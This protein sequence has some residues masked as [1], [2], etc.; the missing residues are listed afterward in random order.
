M[1]DDLI[2]RSHL[3]S[4]LV[5]LL[6]AFPREGWPDRQGFSGLAA[7]WLER[8][9]AFPQLLATLKAEAEATA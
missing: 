1:T 3:P 7:F 6:D 5:T 8:N 2:Q 4:D 9:L